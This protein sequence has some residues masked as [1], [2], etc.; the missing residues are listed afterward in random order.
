MI[1]ILVTNTCANFSA[2]NQILGVIPRVRAKSQGTS[3]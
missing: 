1:L 3:L 2:P